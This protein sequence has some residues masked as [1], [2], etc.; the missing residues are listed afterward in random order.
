MQ[1]HQFILDLV[2][3]AG[4]LA[5]KYLEKDNI[6]II[7]KPD[8]SPVTEA[9]IA[10]NE[11]YIKELTN[12]FINIPIVSEEQDIEL[13]QA[14]HSNLYFLID[15][16]D[17]TKAFINRNGDFV[18]QIAL[19]SNQRP[20]FAAIYNP[21]KDELYY[22]DNEK[23]YLIKNNKTQIIKVVNNKGRTPWLIFPT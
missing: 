6:K 1:N 5:L 14:N 12:K 17:G 20:I 18:T 4:N 9:D 19:M 10:L 22:S 11:L 2:K 13:N 16:I 23:S 8:G 21:L 3:E 7:K 15:P